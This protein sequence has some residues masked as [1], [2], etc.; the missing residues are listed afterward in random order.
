MVHDVRP[1][2]FDEQETSQAEQCAPRRNAITPRASEARWLAHPAGRVARLVFCQRLADGTTPSSRGCVWQ[3]SL[4][5][6]HG[7]G[8][9]RWWLH[10][11]APTAVEVPLEVAV[12][13]AEVDPVDGLVAVTPVAELGQVVGLGA[14]AGFGDVVA[15]A[16]GLD[17]RGRGAVVRRAF[18]RCG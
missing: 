16:V 11:H 8:F 18:W 14:E 10:R 15:V 6:C 4:R 1:A 3:V 13:G 9:E 12:A 17:L 2:G 7:R 5:W